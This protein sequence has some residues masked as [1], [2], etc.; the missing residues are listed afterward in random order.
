MAE[1]FPKAR[2]TSVSNSNNQ[3][4]SPSGSAKCINGLKA[5]AI[6]DLE[7]VHREQG[8]GTG[9]EEP[10]DYHLRHEQFQAA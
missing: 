8:E 10:Q 6:V 5:D 1:R 2:I 4:V 7:G 3:R 9:A